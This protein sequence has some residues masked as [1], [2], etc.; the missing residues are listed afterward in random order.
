MKTMLGGCLSAARRAVERAKQSDRLKI[1][2]S[3]RANMVFEKRA[4]LKELSEIEQSDK[5]LKFGAA[6]GVR[7]QSESV[8]AAFAS[9]INHLSCTDTGRHGCRTHSERWQVSFRCESG[10]PGCCATKLRQ[11]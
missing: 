2:S 9:Q 3:V 10:S 8:G 4:A 6:S 7:R 11:G 1:V 5:L